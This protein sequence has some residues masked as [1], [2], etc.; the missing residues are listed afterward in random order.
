MWF[1]S[2]PRKRT[3]SRHHPA[4]PRCRPALE[5]L[6]ERAVPS[7]AHDVLYVGDGSNNSIQSFDAQTGASLGTFV[8][9][10]A[11]GLH[12]PRGMVFDSAGDLLVADQNV[13]LPIDGKVL[14]YSGGTGSPQGPV[15]NQN[16]HH[17]P[18]DP[19]GMVLRGNVLY[20][21]SFTGATSPD[22]E[23]DRYDATS[24]KF[25]GA[26]SSPPGWTGQFNPRG[27]V[28][29]PDG[30]LYVSAFDSSSPLTGAVVRYD[31][32]TGV[33]TIFAANTGRAP[34]LHRPEGL[35]FGPDGR[36]YVT[37]FRA[38][39]TDTDKIVIINASGAE[40]DSIALDAV[41]QARSFG[42]ALLFGPG[43]HLFVPITG[44]GSDTGA[45]RSYDVTTK[46]F[47]NFVAPGTMGQPWY[48]TFGNTD[49]ATLAYVPPSSG[50]IFVPPPRTQAAI[51]VATTSAGDSVPAP[52][53]PA[54]V[55]AGTPSPVTPAAASAA[56][57]G[58]TDLLFAAWADDLFID[59]L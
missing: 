4:A 34:D 9:R 15:V 29:G 39:A 20:V 37:G 26:F 43:G 55:V 52:G 40:V 47:T 22:G 59:R 19:R 8:P 33:G 45:V 23:V 14:K 7:A 11:G 46:T 58:A 2:W 57:T 3:V 13:N 10:S 28:F 53:A 51:T 18:F 25:L 17:A 56:P 16:D 48:L 12:G 1:P 36:L 6:E 32:G 27:V 35:T 31:V 54:L 21:A 24:G 38:D 42:Q 49:A 50:A 44:L 30:G 41:G 5:A